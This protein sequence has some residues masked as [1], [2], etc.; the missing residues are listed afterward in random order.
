MAHD[1]RILATVPVRAVSSI[2]GL[3]I[4][5]V[6]DLSPAYFALVMATGIVSIAADVSGMRLIAV[7]LFGLNIVAY[8]LLWLLTVLRFLRYP[9]GSFAT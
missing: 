3:V 1:L 7:A 2:L 8:V 4:T 5:E 6:K 9:L